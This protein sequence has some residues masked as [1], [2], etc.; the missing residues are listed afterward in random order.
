MHRPT[1][2]TSEA[3]TAS[4]TGIFTHFGRIC[5]IFNVLHFSHKCTYFYRFVA[6]LP[7]I[8]HIGHGGGAVFSRFSHA[9]GT[10]RFVRVSVHRGGVRVV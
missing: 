9:S 7:Y 5:L 2:D 4:I 1:S 10:E 8:Q 6:H 3:N